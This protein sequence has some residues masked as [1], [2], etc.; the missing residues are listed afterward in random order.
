MYPRGQTYNFFYNGGI[1]RSNRADAESNKTYYQGYETKRA[2]E[3][4]KE[5]IFEGYK[6]RVDGELKSS[7]QLYTQ[8]KL[9][10]RLKTSC[11]V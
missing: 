10:S 6:E 1:Y 2:K 4:Q 9:K 3:G 7:F 5:T 8:M 11:P